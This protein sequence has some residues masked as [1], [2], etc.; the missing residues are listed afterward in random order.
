MAKNQ[1]GSSIGIKVSDDVKNVLNQLFYNPR[2]PVAFSGVDKIYNYFKNNKDEFQDFKT[3][4]RKDIKMWLNKQEA[5]TSHRPIRRKFRR[6]RV[7]FSL[8]YQWDTDTA[9]M[10]KYKDHNDGFRF[11]AV[12]IDI[13]SRYL[14]T[15]PMKTLTGIEM[16]MRSIFDNNGVQPKKIR[17]DQGSE[18]KNREMKRFLNDRGIKHIFTYYETKANYAERVIKT[19]KLKIRKCLTGKETFR[20]VDVLQDLTFS[21]N[22]SSHRSIKMQ[23]SKAMS[24][25]PYTVWSN[26][27][28]EK[29]QSSEAYQENKSSLRGTKYPIIYKFKVGD[30]VK[31]SYLK[32]TWDREY[33]EKWTGE[34]FTIINRKLNQEIPMYQLKDYNNDIIDSFFYEPELQLAYIGDEVSYK[35][36]EIIKKRKRNKISEV[37][38]KWKGWPKN[39]IHGS[40]KQSCRIYK[41]C[42]LMF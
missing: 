39:S 22:H 35:I 15:A 20:W 40:L 7:I 23:P 5:Y 37:L 32:S 9:N 36:E 25:D 3:L 38:V 16:V 6:P 31:I 17:S 11:F 13:F 30:R 2:S 33:S 12:F 14:Y 8:N 1:N 10:V 29:I 27:Y 26:Q 19:L 28:G 41:A 18:Y 24:E 4:T 42:I 21:Y 34:I